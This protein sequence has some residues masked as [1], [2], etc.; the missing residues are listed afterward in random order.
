MEMDKRPAF[1]TAAPSVVVK[2]LTEAGYHFK[3]TKISTAGSYRIEDADWNDKDFPH[4]NHVHTTVDAIP[5]QDSK[6]HRV[7]IQG[8]S[9]AALGLEIPMITHTYEWRPYQNVV[10]AS[11][12]FF[13]LVLHKDIQRTESGGCKI[14]SY[15]H[16][17]AKG[18]FRFFV[19]LASW[20]VARSNRTILGEDIEMREQRAG[21]RARGHEFRCSGETYDFLETSALHLNNVILGKNADP[22]VIDFDQIQSS[23][24]VSAAESGLLK[25]HVLVE[26]NRRSV[27]NSICP[28]EGAPLCPKPQESHVKCPWH[29]KM[30]KP[31][32]VVQDGKVVSKDEEIYDFEISLPKVT[33]RLKPSSRAP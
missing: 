31:V 18:L 28:H 5:V 6:L 30:N 33:V 25:F 27:W 17:G 7:A 16:V 20:F 11:T 13:I 4:I 12:L 9:I 3:T 29:G 14:D 19:P 22:V 26:G 10:I 15:Y 23:R 1:V 32:L 21:L 24:M 2:R 8:L